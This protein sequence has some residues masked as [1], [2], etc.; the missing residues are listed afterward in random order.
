ML[1][2]SPDIHSPM[3]MSA[4]LEGA[5]FIVLGGRLCQHCNVGK[6]VR[7]WLPAQKAR[8]YPEASEA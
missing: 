8:L 3:A 1:G 5:T 4:L 2:L 6:M 7:M